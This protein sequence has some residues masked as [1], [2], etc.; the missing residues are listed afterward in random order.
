MFFITSIDTVRKPELII[1][2]RESCVEF[3]DG[4]IVGFFF[5]FC[6]VVFFPPPSFPGG[7]SRARAHNDAVRGRERGLAL[8]PDNRIR[9]PLQLA[10]EQHALRAPFAQA[11]YP[12]RTVALE[13]R[14]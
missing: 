7:L 13:T 10:G 14:A 12:D 3:A 8:C 2:R 9:T 6:F 4:I 1:D 11:D 5:V